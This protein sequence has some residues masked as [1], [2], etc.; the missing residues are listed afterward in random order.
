MLIETGF[1]LARPLQDSWALLTDLERVAPA[2]PGVTVESSDDDG[3][4]AVMRVKVGPVTASYRTVVSIVSLDEAARTAVLRASGK[5]TRGPGTVDATVTATMAPE[6]DA[7]TAVQLS[8]DLSVT[9]KMA[10][11]GGGVMTEVAQKLLRQFADQL[12]EQLAEPAAAADAGA[13][14]PPVQAEPVDLGRM[15]GSA[16]LPKAAPALA[17]IGLALLALVLL[18]RRR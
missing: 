5:E 16:V 9:G 6:G 17:A 18:R 10:Q 3:L 4:H 13:P 8:T 1:T 12:E 11:F 14:S 15:A 7:A 2:M